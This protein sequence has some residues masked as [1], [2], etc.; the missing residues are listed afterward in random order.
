[1]P[2]HSDDEQAIDD[3]SFI[4]TLSLGSKRKHNKALIASVT[5]SD[6]ITRMTENCIPRVSATFRKLQISV[7]ITNICR[8]DFISLTYQFVEICISF[9]N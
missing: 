8:L 4:A 6:V 9:S 2:D 5:L 7:A 1:M 3:N